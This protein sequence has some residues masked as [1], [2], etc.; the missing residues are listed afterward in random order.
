MKELWSSSKL[1]KKQIL[2]PR[3]FVK[4]KYQPRVF[5]GE[6]TPAAFGVEGSLFVVCP[7]AGAC[8][9]A[10]T[11]CSGRSS[12]PNSG[13][14]DLVLVVSASAGSL[15]TSERA[16]N[17]SLPPRRGPGAEGAGAGAGRLPLRE[18]PGSRRHLG[19]R[20]GAGHRER[21]ARHQLRPAVGHRRVR[22]PH[23]AHRPLRQHRPGAVL[24]RPRVR[25]ASGAAA[26]ESA[27]R[28]E[29]ACPA[30]ACACPAPVGVPGVPASAHVPP[31][32]GGGLRPR[33]ADVRGGAG[34]GAGGC[35]AGRLRARSP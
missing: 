32:Q 2:L 18:V 12:G 30:S 5:T 29:C 8:V 24:L 20:P 11:Q 26:G 21:P 7:G 33:T 6:W 9:T 27:G 15:R 35:S 23:R 31:P 34:Q 14:L 17:P 3:S 28:R 10:A 4:K 25:P 19:G 22:A 16:S 13:L 1:R